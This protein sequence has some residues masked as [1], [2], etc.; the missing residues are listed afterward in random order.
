M[1]LYRLSGL[2][3]FGGGGGA[4]TGTGSMLGRGR[5]VRLPLGDRAKAPRYRTASSRSSALG[6]D[7]AM[8]LSLSTAGPRR[9]PSERPD[10][11]L[12]DIHISRLVERDESF[13]SRFSARCGQ[14]AERRFAHG[15]I[16]VVPGD[17]GHERQ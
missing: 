6:S 17:L 15:R 2:G 7:W 4:S 3:G 12:L 11:K 5:Y 14:L 9:I 16:R 10:N 8:T 13:R 1:W